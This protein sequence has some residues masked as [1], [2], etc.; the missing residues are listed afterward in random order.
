MTKFKAAE[1]A[2]LAAA[3]R[4]THTV[5]V[6]AMYNLCLLLPDLEKHDLSAWRIGAYGGA[7]MPTATIDGVASR[8]PG[9]TL[10][11]AYGATE[12]CSPATIMPPGMTAEHR[13]SV[14]LAVPCG[15]ICVVDES[16][17]EVPR[18]EVGEIWIAGPMVV[19]GY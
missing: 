4:I 7:P 15:E 16:G 3:E 13:D 11:N 12:T 19:P 17:D 14:G 10:M 6:P 1:F 9:L 8:L 18:G 2:Q 5:M